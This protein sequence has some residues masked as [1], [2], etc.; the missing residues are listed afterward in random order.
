MGGQN[1]GCA[2]LLSLNPCISGFLSCNSKLEEGLRTRASLSVIMEAIS[3]VTSVLVI[4][5]QLEQCGKR[6][7]QLKDNFRVAEEVNL[8]AD[9]VSA[10]QAL[11]GI[12]T[13]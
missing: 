10:C 9:E 7:H 2:S 12:F 1:I 13:E 3:T 5:N 6:L 4:Y 8:L 11:F